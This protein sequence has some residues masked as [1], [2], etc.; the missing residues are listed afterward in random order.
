MAHKLQPLARMRSATLGIALLGLVAGLSHAGTA[1]ACGASPEPVYVVDTAG[2]TSTDTPLNAPLFVYLREEPT[3]SPG[4]ALAPSLTLTIEGSDETM[5]VESRGYGPELVWV[6]VETLEP[7]TTYE[8]HFNPGYEGVPD[9]IW[10]FTTG[11]ETQTVLSLEGKLEVTLEGGTQT[12]WQ[13]PQNACPC[14]CSEAEMAA[15]CTTVEV[16]VTNA[17]VKLPRTVDG[18]S[19]RVGTVVLTDDQPYDF[20]IPTKGASEPYWGNN[21][22]SSH[23]VDLDDADVTELLIPLPEGETA[24]R[25]CFAFAAGDARGDQ[26]VQSLCLDETFPA[27][28]DEPAATP[29]PKGDGLA[30]DQIKPKSTSEGCSLSRAPAGSGGW[31]AL[32][33]LLSAL[34][35]RRRRH[36]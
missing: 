32:V 26:A 9:T 15:A 27:A 12:V 21:V 33:G 35:R 20:S 3:A 1:Q 7:E 19:K 36:A 13:C 28:T 31:L 6:P 29:D 34:Q 23:Y 17:R 2:P 14:G 4:Q 24:Y 18:F 8:A 25:P 22:S 10:T 30:N 11:T 5:A 16:P